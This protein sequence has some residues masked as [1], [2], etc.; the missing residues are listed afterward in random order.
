[1]SR[2]GRFDRM[3]RLLAL[4]GLALLAAC[5]EQAPTAPIRA[6]TGDAADLLFL[7]NPKLLECETAEEATQSLLIGSE[8]GTISIGGTSVVFPA[9]ALL[10]GT[11]VTLKIPASRYVEVEITTSGRTYF[12][13]L[14]RVLRPI[15]TIS[16]E[17]C[18][19]GDLWLKALSAWYIDSNTKELLEKQ[20]SFDNK[21]TQ[22]VTFRANHFSGYAIAF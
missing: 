5:G 17:R 22:K 18:N 14:D 6:S 1:M 9:G 7:S 8:G 20:L 19:R 16:Y 4:A 15:V 3:R 13:D 11:L 12:G 21:L 10:D 2:V